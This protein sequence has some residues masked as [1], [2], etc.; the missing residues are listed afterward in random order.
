LK[1][2]DLGKKDYLSVLG[3][4]LKLLKEKQLGL[5][6]ND[7]IILVE[8]YPVYTCGKS[9]KEEHLKFLKKDE[10]IEIERGGSITFHGIGQIVAYPIINLS[11][12]KLS[13]KNYVWILEESIIRTLSDFGINAFRLEGKRGVFTDKG[14]IGFIGIRVSKHITMHGISLN[15]DVDKAFFDRIIPCGLENI[16]VA[17]V[18]DFKDVSFKN[19]KLKL[20]DNLKKLL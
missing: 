17:N 7:F 5:E 16:P 14:K 3:L 6:K 10:V 19:V 13:V 1:I 11:N 4:Q 9:T 2:L 12:R 20:V 8:H 15:V 18:S